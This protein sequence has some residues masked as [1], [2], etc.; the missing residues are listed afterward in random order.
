MGKLSLKGLSASWSVSHVV[1]VP[2]WS[3][4]PAAKASC[5]HVITACTGSGELRV[6]Q[7]KLWRAKVTLNLPGLSPKMWLTLGPPAGCPDS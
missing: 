5:E 3:L 1:E 6:D 4:G 2:A 7:C